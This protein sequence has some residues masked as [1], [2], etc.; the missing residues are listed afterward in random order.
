MIDLD[1]QFLAQ[2]RN[3][4]GAQEMF[5]ERVTP[6]SCLAV[7]EFVWCF[8]LFNRLLTN[9]FPY[10][11]NLSRSGQGVMFLFYSQKKWTPVQG[12]P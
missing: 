4:I 12:H 6:F 9:P 5:A 2:C 11:I 10:S 7:P 8:R 1:L 3:T